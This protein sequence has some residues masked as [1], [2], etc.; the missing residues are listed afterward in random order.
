VEAVMDAIYI[1]LAGI[2]AAIIL[3]LWIAVRGEIE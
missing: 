1:A 2:G 3:A